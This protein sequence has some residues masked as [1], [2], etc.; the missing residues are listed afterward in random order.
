M[1]RTVVR[2]GVR[3]ARVTA[4]T[5]QRIDYV[6]ELGQDAF[7]DLDEC[8]RVWTRRHGAPPPTVGGKYMRCVGWRSSLYSSPTWVQFYDQR[9]T[10]LEFQ[11][12]DAMIE[13]LLA[14]LRKIDCFAND[15]T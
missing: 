1:R 12:G 8:T 15:V 11:T 5:K 13:E 10:R 7:V 4:V 9:H 2:I 3:N 6:D 14:G